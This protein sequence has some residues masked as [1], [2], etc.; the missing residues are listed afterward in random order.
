MTRQVPREEWQRYFETLGRSERM[1]ATLEVVSGELGDQTE[2]ERMPL[3]SV[4]YDDR[5]DAITVAVGGRSERYPVVLWHTLESPKRVDVREEEGRPT[6]ILV[7]TADGVR[8]ILRL[9]P[10]P[11]A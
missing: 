7:E 2:A 4:S 6:A 3:S 11:A 10:E 8:T 9:I 1:R 5:R